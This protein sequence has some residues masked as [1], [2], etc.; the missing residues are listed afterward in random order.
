MSQQMEGH[1]DTPLARL[2]HDL[3]G[4]LHLLHKL[5]ASLVVL[6]A[7]PLPPASPTHVLL[8]TTFSPSPSP[9][10]SRLRTPAASPATRAGTPLQ[11][12]FSVPYSP[13]PP[14]PAARTLQPFA[15]ASSG[16][17]ASP[18]TL[19]PGAAPRRAASL[20]P[21][22]LPPSPHF[23]TPPSMAAPNKAAGVHCNA[24]VLPTSGQPA[25]NPPRSPAPA[26]PPATPRQLEGRRTQLVGAAHPEAQPCV[27]GFELPPPLQVQESVAEL[28][29]LGQEE[30]APMRELVCL[31]D[32][33]AALVSAGQG[34]GAPM[35]KL[36][37]LRGL[38]AVLE[39][40]GLGRSG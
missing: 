33:V 9:S 36:V 25:G 30:G 39:S 3:Q 16:P 10:A 5:V 32:V 31:R 12:T 27:S 8:T 23:C 2:P 22:T 19:A 35:R 37:D 17:L 21:G 7:A 11:P 18:P 20:N 29:E 38:V 26:R 6:S 4:R 13:S 28:Q 1:E 14:P 15:Q 34:G 40:A 24:G